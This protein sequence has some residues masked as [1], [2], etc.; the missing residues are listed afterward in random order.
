[1]T[2]DFKLGLG[3]ISLVTI[4]WGLS[5]IS[6]KV[7]ISVLNPMSLAAMQFIV[8]SI[9]MTFIHKKTVG[10]TVVEKSDYIAFLSTGLLGITMYYYLQ[11]NAILYMSTS[12]AS[13]IVASAPI[14]TLIAD[15]GVYKLA[16]KAKHIISVM[17]SFAGVYL[18]VM[19]GG[20]SGDSMKG[21]IMMGAAII[22][23]VIYLVLSKSLQERY[24]TLSVTYYQI[25]IGT[26]FLIPFLLKEG[27]PLSNMTP[28]IW[29]NVM[30]LGVCC[31]ALGFY[32]YL[33]SQEKLGLTVTSMFL[34]LIPVVT[35]V[36][37][38]LILEENLSAY[39]LAGGSLVIMSVCIINLNLK[40]KT[41]E[42]ELV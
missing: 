8:A 25:L 28:M 34:N 39:Q 19:Q 5:F 9:I 15:V 13:M 23:W 18:I 29:T 4:F 27:I 17:L 32:L 2:K 7:V 1:M 21:Y 40:K 36:S 41:N 26:F 37:G 35:V 12:S 30:Y 42:D 6:I 20:R 16:I 24:N 10:K 11:N 3:F 22:V 14:I 31:S 38:F 33:L